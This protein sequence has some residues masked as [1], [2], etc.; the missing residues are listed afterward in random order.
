MNAL[1]EV[2]RTI[3]RIILPETTAEKVMAG[4]DSFGVICSVLLFGLGWKEY[5]D[6]ILSSIVLVLTIVSIAVTVFIKLDSWWYS[7]KK[8]KHG[9]E[10][11][12]SK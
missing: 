6:G 1:Y 11:D 2:V 8:R 5:V 12:S 10:G 9:K 3:F 4:V 7:R